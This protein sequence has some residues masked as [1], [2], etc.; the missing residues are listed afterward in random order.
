M[1][2]LVVVA[3]EREMEELGERS[4]RG[5]FEGPIRW[6][7]GVA[8]ESYIVRLRCGSLISVDR[9]QPML[10]NVHVHHAIGLPS[11]SWPS[12]SSPSCYHRSLPRCATSSRFCPWR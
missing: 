4:D 1:M 10:E 9:K 8:D 6:K 3:N 11:L 7:R 2:I 5:C 12:M